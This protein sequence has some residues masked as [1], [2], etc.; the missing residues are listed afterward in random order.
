MIRIIYIVELIFLLVGYYTF[1]KDY[2]SKIIISLLILN[3]INTFF[4]FLKIWTRIP[5]TKNKLASLFFVFSYVIVFFQKYIDLV[6]GICD[7][8]NDTFVSANIVVK[9]CLISTIGLTAFYLGYLGFSSK[10]K[11]PYKSYQKIDITFLRYLLGISLILYV[12]FNQWVF[13][14]VVYNQ[15]LLEA[16][17]GTMTLYSGMLLQIISFLYVAYSIYNNQNIQSIGIFFK[18]MGFIFHLSVFVYIYMNLLVGDRGPIM[19]FLLLYL[20]SF[21]FIS[22]KNIK[23]WKLAIIGFFVALL[24]TLIGLTRQNDET[25]INQAMVSINE[26][27]NTISP[28]TIELAG[29]VNTLHYSVSTVPEHHPFLWGSFQIRQLFASVPFLGRIVGN[30]LNSG[31]QYHSSA[32]FITWIRQGEFYQY[33]SGTS[34]NADLYL[35]FGVWG[36]LLGLFLWGW[37]LYK[38]EKGFFLCK[39]NVVKIILYL[40]AVTYSIYIPRA[41]ILDFFNYCMF[42]LIL[43]FFYSKIVSKNENN[44]ISRSRS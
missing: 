5:Y 43:H 39:K 37:V 3:A 8:D 18:K 40:F 26:R 35:S 15:A 10:N 32:F 2:N 4:F 33:G 28:L 1:P 31:F 42:T 12:V 13:E 24:F 44:I 22:G 14:G 7:F 9:C 21:I 6:L 16:Q 23:I 11:R 38:I 34:C 29:S 27:V 30:F 25:T 41:T 19:Q 36:V 17:A 20:V